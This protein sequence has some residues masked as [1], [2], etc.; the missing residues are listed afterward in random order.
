M[1]TKNPINKGEQHSM[2]SLEDDEA[3]DKQRVQLGGD[4]LCQ[5]RAKYIQ[6]IQDT[7]QEN[8]FKNSVQF[9]NEDSVL[10]ESNATSIQVIPE[11]ENNK[12]KY[13]S[14]SPSDTQERIQKECTQ[15]SAIVLNIL[16]NTLEKI[17]LL[18]HNTNS[19]LDLSKY[20]TKVLHIL[21]RECKDL[22]AKG[23]NSYQKIYEAL[24]DR[25]YVAVLFNTYSRSWKDMLE[26]LQD[27]E[28]ILQPPCKVFY[29]LFRLVSIFLRCLKEKLDTSKKANLAMALLRIIEISSLYLQQE[30]K[31][32][33][34]KA[35]FQYCRKNPLPLF[36]NCY[37]RVQEKK[38]KE[39]E[40]GTITS[41]PIPEE[42]MDIFAKDQMPVEEH[43]TDPSIHSDAIFS[44]DL[45][46]ISIAQIVQ[47]LGIERKN[48]CL[49]ILIENDT[50]K[51]YLQDGMVLHCET[52]EYEGEE[53]FYHALYQEQGRF[54][55][56]MKET[57]PRVTVN[58]PIE[59]LLMEC[60][61]L[62]DEYE[63]DQANLQQETRK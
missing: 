41:T 23:D 62:L 10:T 40:K 17:L 11:E 46:Y 58:L 39:K 53:V 35:I 22:E 34:L 45:S 27:D 9:N 28:K 63:R 2:H 25:I 33:D 59:Y 14:D 43:D 51:I 47:M 42:Q 13:F 61:R 48:G 31:I 52:N 60:A 20:F 49:S 6:L 16:Q 38:E 30:K 5:L 54:T 36:T 15:E 50:I 32:C 4:A 12:T 24:Q 19:E 29:F 8:T 26:K 7:K 1:G 57:A 3:K 55:F 56:D 21:H 18:F 37:S 44:G